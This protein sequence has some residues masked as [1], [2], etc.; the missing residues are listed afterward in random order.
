MSDTL[1]Y[2]EGQ[3]SKQTVPVYCSLLVVSQ[4]VPMSSSR[5]QSLLFFCHSITNYI[6]HKSLPELIV[7]WSLPPLSLTL[8]RPQYKS[9][10][11]VTL[12][13]N[14]I[15]NYICRT[16]KYKFDQL[17]KLPIRKERLMC[18]STHPYIYWFVW[19]HNIRAQR[20]ENKTG[21]GVLLNVN[22]LFRK[23]IWWYSVRDQQNESL[24]SLGHKI[25]TPLK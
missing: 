24:Y 17:V 14:D 1:L 7:V 10:L 21:R 3:K 16:N 2:R 4:S 20:G 13:K 12:H 6:S 8:L 19:R 11:L 25:K 18:Y 15:Q 5:G 23:A 22:G 9:L